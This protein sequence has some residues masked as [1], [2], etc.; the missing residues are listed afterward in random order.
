MKIYDAKDIRNVAVAG[1]ASKGKTTL[2]EA[3]LYIAG[4]T[5]RMGRVAD[6]NTV[7]DY[8]SE[9]KSAPF[10]P[11][12]LLPLLNITQKRLILLILPVFLILPRV[13]LRD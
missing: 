13:L 8:D 10:Q 9:E 5:E 2:T 7:T 6:G 11:Q 1:H 4:A 12:A 3:M